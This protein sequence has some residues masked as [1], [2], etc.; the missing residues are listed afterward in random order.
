MSEP[1]HVYPSVVHMLAAT[2]ARVPAREALVCGGE[3]LSYGEYRA[4]VTHFATALEARG[5]RGE[6]VAIVL[7]NGIDI[8]I[9]MFAVH[10]A[11]AVAV[12]L[13]PLYTERELRLILEDA[14]VQVIVY[15]AGSQAVAEAVAAELGIAHRIGLGTLG[16]RHLLGIGA[17]VRAGLPEPLPAPEDLATLQYTGGTTG[18][19][20]GVMLSHG[21]IALNIAQREALAPTRPDHERLL[22]VMPLF[23]VYGIAMCLHLAPYCAASLAI[24]PRYRPEH[25]CEVL[26]AERITVLAG[27]P[28]LYASLLAFEPF[29]GV[30]TGALEICYSGGAALPTE[31]LK[32]WEART[33]AKIVEGYGQSEAGPVIAFNPQEGLRKPGSVGVPV[34]QTEIQIVDV[35]TGERLLPAGERGEIRVRG[36]QVMLGYRNL[37]EETAKALRDGWL[38]TGDIGELDADGYLYIRDRKKDMVIVS[39]FNVYPREVEEVLYLHE[40][41]GEAAVV[42]V[43]DAYRGEVLKAVVALR[44]GRQLDAEALREHCARHLIKYKVPELVELREELPKTGAGKIDKKPLRA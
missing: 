8:C 7:G 1:P 27:S 17:A 11:G 3:R 42:G 4:A 14:E 28:T 16:D 35:E 9:A 26:A 12:P 34:P 29:A 20:K 10:A 2:A 24:V 39:G 30:D 6:R 18:R 43:P 23:H 44:A 40:A 31:I 32:R 19:S 21:A 38:Y 33:G 22:S 25:V 15:D 36:P 41:V 37:P 5:A 13:N